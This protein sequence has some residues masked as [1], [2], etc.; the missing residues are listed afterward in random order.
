MNTTTIM[1]KLI[2]EIRSLSAT[3]DGMV[4]P[5][6]ILWTDPQRQWW[7]LHPLLLEQLPELIMLGEYA[8]EKRTGPAIWI[9]CVVDRSIDIGLPADR[10]PIIYLPGVSRQELRAGEDSRQELWPLVELMYRGTMWLQ[11]NGYDWTVTAFLTSHDLDV[12]RDRLTLAALNRALPEVVVTPL[13]QLQGRRLEADD[14]DRLLLP[15][16]VLNLLRWL[17]EPQ[18]AKERMGEQRWETFRHQCRAKYAI[19]PD[20]DHELTAAEKL[21]QREGAWQE[22][23]QRYTEAPEA[24]PAI[25]DLLRRA[26][27][28]QLILDGS[29]WPGVN[30]ALESGLRTALEKVPTLPHAD[31]C[32]LICQLEQQHSERR[33][34]V[35]YR[36]G[37]APLVKVL[38]SL[39]VLAKIAQTTVGGHAPADMATVYTEKAWQAN[40]AAWQSLSQVPLDEEMLVRRVVRALLLPWLEKSALSFQS[41]V[42]AHP[43]LVREQENVAA[44]E[45]MCLI[46]V[47][48]L[49]FDIA[50]LLA[51]KLEAEGCR[52]DVRWRWAGIPTVTATAKPAVLPVAEQIIGKS[53]GEDFAP[54][55]AVDGKTVNAARIR[56]AMSTYGYHQLDDE[57]NYGP[58]SAT[59]RGWTEC[60][61]F[62]QLGHSL[63]DDL[64]GHIDREIE[65]VAARIHQLLDA[66]WKVRVITDHGWLWLPGSL[67]KV[68]LPKH[69]T[70]SRWSRCA[71]IA[72]ASQVD[73]PIYPWYWNSTIHFAAAP[74][75]NCFN[76]ATSYAHG[77]VSLEECV[78]P[79]ILVEKQDAS[80]IKASIR[81]LTWRG[82]RCHIE[83]DVSGGTVIADL[84]LE[85]AGGQSVVS[86][87]KEIDT[88]GMASLLVVDDIYEDKPLILILHDA[89]GRIL[90]QY[91]TKVGGS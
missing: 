48:G 77:G 73:A 16:V 29:S 31:A 49:R 27:P 45:G 43:L 60:G 33:N 86:A 62:D 24:Y 75:I 83:A 18:T 58:M 80:S 26:Q 63:N 41:L 66:G 89:S 51:Q 17:N 11:R 19:D 32:Q 23:W 50:K 36:L 84:R 15:D 53:L 13:V 35:W 71:V 74:G 28:Q 54:S 82:M 91:K 20:V 59:A 85:H 6:A 2:T 40:A 52:V 65:R 1:D 14:F 8:P 3:P 57:L 78:I 55:F 25:P 81:H 21:G 4:E 7:S 38:A 37:Q 10:I 56:E 69:L 39:A 5:A 61:S 30:D 22:V 42:A 87:T 79:D 76:A 64:P 47:D 12:A 70:A 34:W 67:P 44:E 46:F 88:D 9:R 72:G 90:A 68:D